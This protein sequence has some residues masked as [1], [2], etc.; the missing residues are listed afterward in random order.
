MGRM[1][2]KR[3]INEIA[4]D[5][6]IYLA[7]F[8]DG[9]GTITIMRFIRKC[10]RRRIDY[11]PLISVTNTN[12]EILELILLLTGVGTLSKGHKLIHMR[13]QPWKYCVTNSNAI[14]LAKQLYP[15]LKIK[16]MNAALLVE[17]EKT[18]ANNYLPYRLTNEVLANREN[19]TTTINSLNK[20]GLITNK[21]GGDFC[22]ESNDL[23][24]VCSTA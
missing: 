12:K 23:K 5:D 8:I 11:R 21:T 22:V 18:I 15:Y 4:K 10:R 7:G 13:K 24:S 20:R 19:L 9:E 2:V 14:E 1:R 16:K 6:L 17:Y 3:R